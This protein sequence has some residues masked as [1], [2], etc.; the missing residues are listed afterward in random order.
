MAGNVATQQEGAGQVRIDNGVPL[1]AFE[2]KQGAA[3]LHAC[4]VDQDVDSDAIGG[5]RCQCLLDG[6]FVGNVE[7]GGQYMMAFLGEN[8]P[9]GFELVAITTMNNDLGARLSESAS[10]GETQP[11]GRTC[12]E[13][14][15]AG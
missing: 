5:K 13:C 12:N 1:V 11:A 8:T 9:R 14:C 3:K 2:L 4:V 6:G 7:R 10:H 15:A